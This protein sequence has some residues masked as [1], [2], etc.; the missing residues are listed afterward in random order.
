MTLLT[1][2]ITEQTIWEGTIAEMGPLDSS[3]HPELSIPEGF[4]N[5]VKASDNDPLFVTVEIE[6]GMSKSKRKWKPEHLKLVVDKVNKDRMAGNL[7]HPLLDPQV[8]ERGFPD[9]QVVWVVGKM[10]GTNTAAFKGYVLKSGK[11]REL[12]EMGLIDG[13]SIF[14][15]SRMKPIQGGYEVLDFNPETIDFARKGRSGMKSRVVSL[16]GEQS[17]ERGGTVE[18]RDI[19]ALSVDE[20]KTHAPLVHKA[21]QDEALAPLTAKVG[22]MEAMVG[23]LQ[24]D[25]DLLAEIKKLLK[26]TDGENPLEKVTNLIQKIEDSASAEI[27]DFVKSLISKKV[28]TER[29]QALVGR[30]IGEMHSEYEGPLTEELKKQIETDF[31]SKIEGDE[32]IKT[33]VG[34]MAPFN[35]DNSGSGSGGS[36]VGGRSRAGAGRGRGEPADGVVRRTDNLVVRKQRV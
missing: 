19:A 32:D 25:A 22:E 35:D 29:G 2:E 34:E 1:E 10:T 21:I 30:L 15:D 3:T 33:L 18:A 6:A 36:H 9:P 17:T 24:P 26:L 14:G 11:S 7:G 31:T 23:T 13:V 5:Q 27:K 4:L 8:Y 12:L 20:I 28:K 16:T